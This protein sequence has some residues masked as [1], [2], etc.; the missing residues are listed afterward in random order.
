MTTSSVTAPE[1]TVSAILQDRAQVDTI[2]RRLLDQGISRD[3]ISVIGKNFHTETRIS[4]FLT[5]KDLVLGGLR[6]GGIF[7]SLA[8]SVLG[9]LTGVGVLFIPFVGTVVAAGPI[10]A[11]LLGAATGAIAGA[12][13]AGLVSTFVA[14]GLP[15]DKAT[16][17]QT[18]VEAGHFLMMVEAGANQMQ[19]VQKLLQEAG[20]D[21]ISIIN[22]PL[23]RQRSGQIEAPT[24]LAPEV[25]SHLSEA[26][27]QVYIDRY[28]AA[29]IETNDEQQAEHI[30]W[31]AVHQQF[32]EDEHGVWSRQ[33]A[34]V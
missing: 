21:E 19:E 22:T 25:R 23:P 14:L 29:L 4:G 34:G 12:A 9:L 2:I 8:G 11:V 30:A 31:D 24:H 13:G 33:K 16:L 6:Q 10:G 1:N 17:Y 5:R 15:E 26:A 18:R 7:G 20:G 32:D 3:R 27:Q 28:N